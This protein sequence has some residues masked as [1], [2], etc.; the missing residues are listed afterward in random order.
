MCNLHSDSMGRLEED[1]SSDGVGKHPLPGLRLYDL[2][3]LLS[4]ANTANHTQRRKG[5]REGGRKRERGGGRKRRFVVMTRLDIT[6]YDYNNILYIPQVSTQPS[7]RKS[8]F[9]SIHISLSPSH[10]LSGVLEPFSR[11][12]WP[13]P[14]NTQPMVGS[15]DKHLQLASYQHSAHYIL[16]YWLTKYMYMYIVASFNCQLARTC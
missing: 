7:K 14:L 5:G 8:N 6:Y 12:V 13:H 3:P 10:L 4:I 15:Y 1:F 11:A 9:K 16:Q 2:H